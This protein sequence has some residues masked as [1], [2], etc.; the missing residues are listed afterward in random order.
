MRRSPSLLLAV[1]SLALSLSVLG[2]HKRV[3][4]IN[5]YQGRIRDVMI[6]T[7]A[8]AR[9]TVQIGRS[10]QQ[11]GLLAAA[12]ELTSAVVSMDLQKRIARAAP[13]QRVRER[14]SEP[15]RQRVV[16]SF[17]YAEV[18]AGG[19]CD[20]R[21]DVTTQSYGITAYTAE[22][23]LNYFFNARV[24]MFDCNDDKKIWEMWVNWQEPITDRYLANDP[25][26][27]V[28]A[29]GT[30]I[31]LISLSQLSDDQLQ[32]MFDSLAESAGHEIANQMEQDAR[33]RLTAKDYEEI[34]ARKQQATQPA[35][36]PAP[37]AP[38]DPNRKV[39]LGV[40]LVETGS[41]VMIDQVTPGGS[42]DAAGVR[43][44]DL[45]VS[46]N[47][48]KISTVD[49]VSQWVGVCK[50]GHTLTLVVVRYNPQTKRDEE[51][52]I[53]VLMR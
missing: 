6:T 38:P 43:P 23:P 45:L 2:C 37:A 47:G 50:P 17:G 21:L 34:A 52:E 11:S 5:Q 20:A 31:N 19:Q 9:P 10:Q 24:D 8:P 1:T 33:R 51:V 18:G 32:F 3:N 42:A 14:F 39:S 25:R 29:A 53:P 28:Q 46:I 12:S 36:E 48:E 22:S 15:Y 40:T 27:E 44:R 16:Q 13:G 4:K 35:A 7:S 49:R 26:A 30:V 41:G